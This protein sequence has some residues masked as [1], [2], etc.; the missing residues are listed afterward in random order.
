MACCL[1][2]AKDA[3][4]VDAGFQALAKVCDSFFV[5]E[6]KSADACLYLAQPLLVCPRRAW[7]MTLA[8]LQISS[9]ISF[10]SNPLRSLRRAAVAKDLRARLSSFLLLFVSESFYV[11]SQL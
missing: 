5:T 1:C 7:Q 10:S 4:N 6:E 11:P 3:V 9:K 2:S 8:M